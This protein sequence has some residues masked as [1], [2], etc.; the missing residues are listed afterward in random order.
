MI[1]AEAVAGTVVGILGEKIKDK[2]SKQPFIPKW[3]TG[4]EFLKAIDEFSSSE[5]KKEK[6]L[7]D[8][9]LC[10]EKFKEEN[11]SDTI[12]VFKYFKNEKGSKK[13]IKYLER[14]YK[15]ILK[16]N[17]FGKWLNLSL[18]AKMDDFKGFVKL[19]DYKGDFKPHIRESARERS[20]RKATKFVKNVLPRM[21]QTFILSGNP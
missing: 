4:K 11:D 5:K 20:Y 15:E 16:G 14:F 21:D 1:I 12:K 17:N 9:S 10:L 6:F 18:D 7:K 2:V 13:F 3:L 19:A 8:H